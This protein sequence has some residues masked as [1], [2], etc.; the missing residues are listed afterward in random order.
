M[1]QVFHAGTARNAA[2]E[3][4]SAGGRVLNVTALGKDVAEAQARAY[5]VRSL[6]IVPAVTHA[7]PPI[8]LASL[9]LLL[10]HD[11]ELQPKRVVNDLPCH[12]TPGT[13][14]LLFLL[15]GC[16]QIE[17]ADAYYRRDIGWKGVAR[18]KGQL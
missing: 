4:V 11:R 7:N 13:V 2:G 5:E 8:F 12:L 3:V 18:L 17:W 16:A 1:A 6:Y 15:Q 9:A 10:R 14:C